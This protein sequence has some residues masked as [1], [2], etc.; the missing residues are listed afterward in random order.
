MLNWFKEEGGG[1][2]VILRSCKESL[3]LSFFILGYQPGNRKDAWLYM[4][5]MYAPVI[6]GGT[7][8]LKVQRLGC[9]RFIG[10]STFLGL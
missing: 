10:F 7:F 9:F 2:I 5:Y 1:D 3:K 4:L 6:V 8:I